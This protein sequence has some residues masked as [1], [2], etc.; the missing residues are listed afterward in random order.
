M[1]R[2]AEAPK[3]SC[4]LYYTF[5]RRPGPLEGS[6]Q[7]L[8]HIWELGGSCAAMRDGSND[9]DGGAFAAAVASSST[10]FLTPRQV[11]I[12]ASRQRRRRPWARHGCMFPC[13]ARR[14]PGPALQSQRL[15]PGQVGKAAPPPPPAQVTSAVVVIAVDLSDPGA[16][17]HSAAAWLRRTSARLAETYAQFEARGMRLPGQLRQRQRG[18]GLWAGHEDA[19]L[20]AHSGERGGRWEGRGRGVCLCR[21]DAALCPTRLQPPPLL[22]FH[23]PPPRV[24]TLC[25]GISLV[26]VGTKWDAPAAAPEGA[27]AP[28]ARE[29]VARALRALAHAHGAHLLYSGGLQPG[30]GAGG[31]QACC[32]PSLQ[33]AHARVLLLLSV[34]HAA[35]PRCCL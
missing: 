23:Q 3:P 5:A 1:V 21:R 15:P 25:A 17:P 4:D 32:P 22:P 27:S 16:A 18:R 35:P 13:M 28:A 8:A 34:M 31:A 20:V 24:P 11:S 30:G 10:L 26:L 9:G 7:E 33:P 2:Q 12:A 29:A 19:G 14:R 6:R